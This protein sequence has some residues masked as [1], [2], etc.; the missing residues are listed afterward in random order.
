MST[1]TLALSLFLVGV[2][3]WP[4]SAQNGPPGPDGPGNRNEDQGHAGIPPWANPAVLSQLAPPQ[5]NPAVDWTKFPRY[6]PPPFRT[7]EMPHAPRFES[8]GRGRWWLGGLAAG[9]AAAAAAAG[10]FRPRRDGQQE[11]FLGDLRRTQRALDYRPRRD[12]QG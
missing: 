11:R 4:A 10:A 12:G 5:V 2:M 1:K 6:T 9:G 7:V 3:A 8:A